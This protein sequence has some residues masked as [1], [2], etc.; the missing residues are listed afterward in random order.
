MEEGGDSIWRGPDAQALKQ[1]LGDECDGIQI[2]ADGL[3]DTRVAGAAPCSF[4]SR[5]CAL[6]GDFRTTLER[7]YEPWIEPTPLL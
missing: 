6:G 4:S 5:T 7:R 2:K 3:V 1:E